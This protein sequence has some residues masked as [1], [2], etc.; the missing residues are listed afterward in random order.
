[1]PCLLITLT[2][3]S[4]QRSDL[5]LK[6][7]LNNSGTVS[8]GNHP[9]VVLSGTDSLNVRLGLEHTGTVGESVL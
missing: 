7:L 1:M 8:L 3:N 9:Q 6:F 2:L 4:D 5:L